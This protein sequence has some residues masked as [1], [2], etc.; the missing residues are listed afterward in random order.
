[1]RDALA[2]IE[3]PLPALPELAASDPARTLLQDPSRRSEGDAV[4]PEIAAGQVYGVPWPAVAEDH[5]P[6]AQAV[7]AWA[8]AASRSVSA[9]GVFV[10]DRSLGAIVAAGTYWTS[11]LVDR[12]EVTRLAAPWPGAMPNA[13]LLA[14]SG[15]CRVT[16]R[17]WLELPVELVEEMTA[18]DDETDASASVYLV[19]NVPGGDPARSW[20]DLDELLDA[21]TFD[22]P[23]TR[24]ATSFYL[25]FV[26]PS[27]NPVTLARALP[28]VRSNL[29]PR[30]LWGLV[31]DLR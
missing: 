15:S 21:V 11:P 1:M 9:Y 12:L 7:A 18:L 29:G 4:D 17:T 31:Q 24:D 20:I 26:G 25:W 28:R 2:S 14:T 10:H 27:A 30:A 16:V 22:H 5:A 19:A 3:G 8:Q 6:T 23:A 13:R